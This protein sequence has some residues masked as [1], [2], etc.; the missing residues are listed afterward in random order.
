VIER[1][2]ALRPFPTAAPARD[3]WI[4]GTAVLRSDGL[5]LRYVVRGS[6]ADVALPSPVGQ[7][8]RR[9]GLWRAT[10][11]ELFLAPRGSHAYWEFNLSPSGDWN[12]YRFTGYRSGMEEEPAFSSL[13]CACQSRSDV[14]ALGVRLDLGAIFPVIP[15]LEAA[16]AATVLRPQAG[17]TYWALSHPGPEP[18]FHRRDAFRLQL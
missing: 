4:D 17:M 8:L 18:D 1:A 12:V 5:E 9:H 10:C 16:V 6:L 15:R 2:F 14:L 13:P 3:L 7:P 11:F